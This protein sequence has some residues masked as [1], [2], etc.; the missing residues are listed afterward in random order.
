M[1]EQWQRIRELMAQYRQWQPDNFMTIEFG[2]SSW[3]WGVIAYR[4]PK[5]GDIYHAEFRSLDEA[6]AQ[7]ESVIPPSVRAGLA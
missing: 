5:H 4:E 3:T 2:S 7:L 1:E 6:I